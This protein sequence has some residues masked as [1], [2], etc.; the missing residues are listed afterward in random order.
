MMLDDTALHK[1]WIYDKL[2]ICSSM[3]LA[4]VLVPA[5]NKVFKYKMKKKEEHIENLPSENNNY[6]IESLVPFVV[7]Y[8]NLYTMHTGKILQV[9]CTSLECCENLHQLMFDSKFKLY[10]VNESF[11]GTCTFQ[12]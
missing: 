10:E 3:F 11:L 1:L 2:W 6:F 12:W 5:D 4:V 8:L 7:G 9:A